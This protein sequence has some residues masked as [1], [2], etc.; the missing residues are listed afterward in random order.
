MD[1]NS[2]GS[3]KAQMQYNPHDYIERPFEKIRQFIELDRRM[4]IHK[5]SVWPGDTI[6]KTPGA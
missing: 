4:K 1:T 5:E 6:N 3:Q 2:Q